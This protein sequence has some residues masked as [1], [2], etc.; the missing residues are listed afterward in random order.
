MGHAD[1]DDD[2]AAGPSLD[3]NAGSYETAIIVKEKVPINNIPVCT[4][5]GSPLPTITMKSPADWGFILKRYPTPTSSEVVL[6]GKA[7]FAAEFQLRVE[8]SAPGFSKAVDI[9]VKATECHDPS[10]RS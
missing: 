5:T 6:S 3:C 4:S 2:H 1:A 9:V 8:A 7:N 10:C